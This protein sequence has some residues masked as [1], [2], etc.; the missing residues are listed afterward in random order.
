[1]ISSGCTLLYSL[2]ILRFMNSDG[3]MIFLNA[4]R[5]KINQ[6]R[7]RM[8]KCSGFI[9]NERL[10]KREEYLI[11]ILS[12]VL[13]TPSDVLRISCANSRSLLNMISPSN[14]FNIIHAAI[15]KLQTLSNDNPPIM[16]IL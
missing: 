13:C 2:R 4:L 1:M 11:I 5:L 8:E 15:A 3:A 16:G 6:S 7:K 10:L 14:R 12:H 9:T